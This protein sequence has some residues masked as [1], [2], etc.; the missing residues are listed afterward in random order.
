MFSFSL[1]RTVLPKSTEIISAESCGTSSWT[2]TAKLCVKLPD[3]SSKRYFV[4]CIKDVGARALVEGEYHSATAIEAS[5][6]DF[7]PKT[8]GWGQYNDGESM[9]YFYLGDFHDM[10][11]AAA[12]EPEHLIS[13]L[14]ELHQRGVSPTGLFGFPVPTVLGEF[15]RTVTWKKSWAKAF[16]RQLEDVYQV[17]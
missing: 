15:Q 3:G 4:K 13:Q 8:A 9:V 7:T 6:P 16:A 2:K 10:D 5:V 1:T 14:V 12:P 11:L 17:R